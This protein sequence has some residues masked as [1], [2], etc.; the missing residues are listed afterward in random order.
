VFWWF[1]IFFT[2]KAQSHQVIPIIYEDAQNLKN[3]PPRSQDWY[4]GFA[5]THYNQQPT[6]NN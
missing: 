4:Y 6:N 5:V 1:K 2:T 3:E